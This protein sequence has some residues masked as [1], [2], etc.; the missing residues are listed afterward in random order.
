MWDFEAYRG[1]AYILLNLKQ[2]RKEKLEE[3]IEYINHDS[4]EWQ[5]YVLRLII[6]L[7]REDNSV[8]DYEK[9]LLPDCKFKSDIQNAIVQI[10]KCHNAFIFAGD[11]ATPVYDQFIKIHTKI[12]KNNILM[13]LI[14][15][16]IKETE[17]LYEKIERYED[18]LHEFGQ[19]VIDAGIEKSLCPNI[20]VNLN[21]KLNKPYWERYIFWI[22]YK[23]NPKYIEQQY[24]NI[25]LAEKQKRKS[26]FVKQ[27]ELVDRIR[28]SGIF[29]D[30]KIFKKY[31]KST[32]CE[33][34][35]MP[36]E[37]NPDDWKVEVPFN[38]NF[39]E[40]LHDCDV[41]ICIGYEFIAMINGEKFNIDINKIEKE[42][43]L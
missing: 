3:L 1:F 2:N 11:I 33:L 9:S 16:G 4:D 10:K 40:F 27:L 5:L 30:V 15:H 14:K 13:F 25:K 35:C 29:D 12:R 19:Y 22:D 20:V 8:S 41:D 18:I 37:Y 31:N 42:I 21:T 43:N 38:D 28:L 26:D 7:L 23:E 17:S 36:D 6:E 24:D 34:G 39:N 32:A